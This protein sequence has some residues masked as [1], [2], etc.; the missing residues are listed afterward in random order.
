MTTPTKQGSVLLYVIMIFGFITGY[1]YSM[2]SDP[3]AAVPVLDNRFQLTSLK[4]L[5]GARIDESVFSNDQYKALRIFGSLPV[6]A[7][8]GGKDNPFQ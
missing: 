6:Q 8:G 4:N 5:E 2:Q 7:G 3:V 1:L